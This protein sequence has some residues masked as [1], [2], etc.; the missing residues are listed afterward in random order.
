M[1][2]TDLRFVAFRFS[3][4][5][6]AGGQKTLDCIILLRR[7]V[8]LLLQW[9]RLHFCKITMLFE[10]SEMRFGNAENFSDLL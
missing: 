6:F 2:L 10:L 9:L 3:Q 8:V 7:L 5:D 4:V 1:L